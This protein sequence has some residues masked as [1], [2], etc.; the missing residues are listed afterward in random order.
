MSIETVSSQQE[1]KTFLPMSLHIMITILRIVLGG[2]ML[3]AGLDKLISG[4][5]SISGYVSHGSG[6]FAD[7]FTHLASVSGALSPLVIWGEILIG[8]SLILGI[9]L[10]FGAFFGAI[11]MIM[12]YLPYLPQENGWVSQQIIYMLVFVTMIFSNN[13]YF[14]GI[15]RLA[16]KLE[17][18]LPGLRL[19]LG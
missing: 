14:F 9:F 12:Y 18:K 1:Q 19:I 8:L 4:D 10:R 11:L 2:A 7:L 5:F 3:E 17:N 6:P 15:D 13:G 16:M